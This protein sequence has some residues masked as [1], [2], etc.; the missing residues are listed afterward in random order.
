MGDGDA[1]GWEACVAGFSDV[2]EEMADDIDGEDVGDLIT[3]IVAEEDS[4]E[5]AVLEDGE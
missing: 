5:L 2:F 1:E 4:G 3:G